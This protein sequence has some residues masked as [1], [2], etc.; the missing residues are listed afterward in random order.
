MQSDWLKNII[1]VVVIAIAIYFVWTWF[2]K[3]RFMK[4]ELDEQMVE[5]AMPEQVNVV[6]EIES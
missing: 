2:L 4:P 6:D 1:I 5:M 3:D